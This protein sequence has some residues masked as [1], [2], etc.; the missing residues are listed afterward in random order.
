VTDGSHSASLTFDDFNGTLDFASDGNGGTLITDPPAN[1]ARR[2]QVRLLSRTAINSSSSLR[3]AWRRLQHHAR[4]RAGAERS[5]SRSRV[6]DFE[7]SERLH[8]LARQPRFAH[9]PNF[10]SAH[11]NWLKHVAL[12]SQHASDFH[13]V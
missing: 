5:A 10:D 2:G 1:A 6:V 7:R 12:G 13:S 11:P 8:Q 9:D 3:S 4:S